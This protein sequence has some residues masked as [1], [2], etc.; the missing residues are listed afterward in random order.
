MPFTVQGL[1]KIQAAKLKMLAAMQPQGGLGKAVL[2]AT[3]A[4]A[5]GVIQRAHRDTGTLAASIIP[6]VSG[7]R[8]LVYTGAY[9]N[10]KSGTPASVYAPFEEA[11]GGSHALYARTFQEDGLRV[12]EEAG[13]IIIAELP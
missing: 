1:E 5:E 9:Q 4:M 3:K 2:Y 11:R 7:L 8:G 13:K 10:P 12:L 6:R